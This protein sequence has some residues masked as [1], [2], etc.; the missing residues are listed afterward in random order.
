MYKICTRN[1]H[2]QNSFNISSIERDS[3]QVQLKLLTISFQNELLKAQKRSAQS[4]PACMER[5]YCMYEGRI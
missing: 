1:F 2:L 3:E 5:V 4:A